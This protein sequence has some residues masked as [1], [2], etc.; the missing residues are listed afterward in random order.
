MA[1]KLIESNRGSDV[2]ARCS[3]KFKS[4]AIEIQWNVMYINFKSSEMIYRRGQGLIPRKAGRVIRK[5]GT[6]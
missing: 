5:A 2:I 3:G 6:F 1:A 4:T